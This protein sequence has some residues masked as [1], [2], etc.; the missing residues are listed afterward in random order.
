MCVGKGALSAL[1]ED[2]V[3]DPPGRLLLVVSDAR[4]MPLHGRPL[5]E[6]LSAK[7]LRVESLTLAG[8]EQGKTRE[9]KARIEDRLVELGAGRDCAL[10]A[11][12]GGVVGDLAG[13]AAATWHRGVP[14]VQVPTSLLA[15]VDAALGGKTAVNLPQGKNLVGSFHQPLGVYADVSLLRTLTDRDYTDGFAE[16]V[17]TAA[18]ADVRWFRRIEGAVEA[19]RGRDE[20][21][22]EQLVFRAMEIKA[23][24]VRTLLELNKNA[25]HAPEKAPASAPTN[26][27]RKGC[28]F[29]FTPL[30]SQRR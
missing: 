20:K 12:G 15:M 30:R 24:I 27:I 1:V 10:I 17:K 28:Q 2:L 22:L 4:V 5:T 14:V 9:A 7:G 26:E 3:H 16:V 23:R 29:I 18:V 6:R 19:L 21:S 8:A 25:N 11:V 13:F